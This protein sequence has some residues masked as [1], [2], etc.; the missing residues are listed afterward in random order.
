[1]MHVHHLS[2]VATGAAFPCRAGSRL[3]ADR[4]WTSLLLFAVARTL[5]DHDV[6]GDIVDIVTGTIVL[7]D[8]NYLRRIP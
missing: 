8:E 4:A 1:M 7:H 5:P 3:D 6:R 2:E